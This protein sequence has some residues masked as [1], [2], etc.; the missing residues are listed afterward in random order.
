[1]QSGYNTRLCGIRGCLSAMLLFAIP[2]QAGILIELIIKN[3]W[4]PAFAGMT[5]GGLAGLAGLAESGTASRLHG[6]GCREQVF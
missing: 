6:I 5:G 1:M 4:I 3:D 2:A